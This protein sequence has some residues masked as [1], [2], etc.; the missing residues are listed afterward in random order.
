MPNLRPRIL[1]H[2]AKS[3]K[4]LTSA[5]AHLYL[6]GG[7]RLLGFTDGSNVFHVN[8]AFDTLSTHNAPLMISPH[9]S[10]WARNAIV[11]EN[12][13]DAMSHAPSLNLTALQ[14][15]G[16]SLL[17]IDIQMVVGNQL[18][19]GLE[20]REALSADAETNAEVL[21]SVKIVDDTAFNPMDRYFT[22]KPSHRSLNSRRARAV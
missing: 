8:S 5:V 7:E 16:Q 9:R 3:G 1:W 2:C 17:V 22:L 14:T 10:K 6:P 20:S 4:P 21:A 13:I 19:A 15:L 18:V 12:M 11:R